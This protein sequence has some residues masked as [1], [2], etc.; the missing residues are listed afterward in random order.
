MEEK[1]LDEYYKNGIS[2]T[3]MGKKLNIPIVKQRLIDR[4][5]KL[6]RDVEYYNL[7][8]SGGSKFNP[9]VKVYINTMPYRIKELDYIL[10]NVV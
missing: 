7:R 10:D 3:E 6:L 5:E 8:I 4:K 9:Q 2:D 1:H